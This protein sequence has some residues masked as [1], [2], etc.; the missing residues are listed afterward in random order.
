[1][2][3]FLLCMAAGYRTRRRHIC[4]FFLEPVIA[5]LRYTLVILLYISQQRREWSNHFVKICIFWDP[6]TQCSWQIEEIKLNTH[7][8]CRNQ[9][10]LSNRNTYAIQDANTSYTGVRNTVRHQRHKRGGAYK[11]SPPTRYT[12]SPS[13]FRSG[14]DIGLWKCVSACVCICVCVCVFCH[15]KYAGR[16]QCTL[17]FFGIS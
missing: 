14:G 16:R 10:Y 5:D 15:S 11:T 7:Q 17:S 4:R 2:S 6:Q 13:K 1:M 12:V 8:V 3:I 9:N